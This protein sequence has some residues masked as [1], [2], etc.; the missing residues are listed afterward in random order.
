[1]RNFIVSTMVGTLLCSVSAVAGEKVNKTLAL[2]SASSITIENQRGQVS[3]VGGSGDE[4][5][6]QGELDEKA[7]GLTF[8]HDG[9]TIIVKV[10]MPEHQGNWRGMS[11]EKGSDLTI[12]VPSQ[13]KVS[14]S[15]IS[16]DISASNLLNGAEIRTVSGEIK[17]D[18]LKTIVEVNS[19]SGNIHTQD[20]HG[21]LI[22]AAVS[23]DI[24]DK[25][26]SGRIELNAVSGEIESTS[27]AEE[28]VIEVVSGDVSLALQKVDELTVSAVSG[29]TKAQ[30][31]LNENGTVK[32][33]SVSG[34]FD[35]H[36]QS[37]IEASFR[38][39]T[40]AGGDIVNRITS[41]KAEHAKYVPSEKL[42]FV[43]GSGKASV[44]ANT[45]SGT[46][47]VDTK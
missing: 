9:S 6:I 21:K 28:V 4:V 42:S 31:H 15:G 7:E 2:E 14:F 35:M 36:F 11:N 40:N 44:K 8:E 29:E 24:I 32:L 41:D 10:E 16:S 45:V 38:L 20:I 3:V 27:A 46:I 17:L 25:N 43:T 12:S 19:V 23:G 22:A 13:L 5:T 39:K 47:R 18:N 37:G 1:M 30:L 33:S 26:S 34:D